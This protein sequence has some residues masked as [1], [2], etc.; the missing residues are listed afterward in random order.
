MNKGNIFTKVATLIVFLLIPVLGLYFYSNHVSNNVATTE[1][2]RLNKKQLSFFVNQIEMNMDHLAMVPITLSRI[3]SI[4]DFKNV[5]LVE[6][7]LEYIKIKDA[8]IN[9]IELHNVSNSWNNEIVVYSPHSK[10]MISSKFSSFNIESLYKSEKNRWTYQSINIHGKNRRYFSWYTTEPWS[11]NPKSMEA[12]L[13]IGVSFSEDIL[14]ELLDQFKHSGRTD[15]FF[16]SMNGSTITSRTANKEMISAVSNELK[17]E[18]PINEQSEK[19]IKIHNKNYLI[20]YM[21][22][23]KMGWYLVDYVPLDTL[24]SPIH[25]SRNLFYISVLFLLITGIIAAFILYRHVHVPINQLIYGVNSIKKGDYSVRISSSPKNE[26]AFLIKS[27]NEM[28]QQIQILIEKVL[29]E[30]VRSKEAVLK[31]LQSQINPHFLYNCLFFIKN[32]AK[33]GNEKALNDMIHNLAEYYRYTTRVDNPLVSVREEIHLIE[34]YLKIYTLRMERITFN[35][36]IPEEMLNEK[37][38]R[39]ILQ[40]IVE[41]AIVH[42]LEPK[43][44]KGN[45]SI[46]GKIKENKNVIIIEDDGLGMAMNDL[47]ELKEKIQ[48]PV[49]TGNDY[50]IWNVNQRLLLYFGKGSGVEL[51]VPELGGFKVVLSWNRINN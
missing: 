27:Y 46:I 5:H 3:E 48:S 22:A 18:I 11:K 1:I 42:G 51:S 10:E 20:S 44:G 43:V 30:E 41:N 40:P 19:I 35:I 7:P 25:S 33:M 37:I 38:L 50:G 9:T 26:F 8:A 23:P 32:M 45:I 12:N 16:Y 34:N 4:K 14:I 15:P 28:A 31:Q 47:N 39:L 49:N 2:K 21:K 17:K 24:M 6:D 13:I 36:S 29:E